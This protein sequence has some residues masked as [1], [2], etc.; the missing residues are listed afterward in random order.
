[1]AELLASLRTTPG[2][3]T[4]ALPTETR[5]QTSRT[6]P[7]I[8]C[9]KG[10]SGWE[11]AQ[12]NPAG[13]MPAKARA[14]MAPPAGQGTLV[15]WPSRPGKKIALIDGQLGSI[16]RPPTPGGPCGPV[17]PAGPT[18]PAGPGRPGGPVTPGGPGPPTAPGGPCGPGAP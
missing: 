9:G 15:D 1:M 2:T 16:S 7:R 11:S 13:I 14:S 10:A 4:R 17:S 18:G 12:T 8:C 3:T 5:S 6:A